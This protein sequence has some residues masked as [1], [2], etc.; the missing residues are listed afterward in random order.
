M[1]GVLELGP[2]GEATFTAA[3][4]GYSWKVDVIKEQLTWLLWDRISDF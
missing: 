3:L 2:W 4:K 1:V